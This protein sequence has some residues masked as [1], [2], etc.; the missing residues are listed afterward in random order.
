MIKSYQRAIRLGGGRR[1][2]VRD[3]AVVRHDLGREDNDALDRGV[4][5][6]ERLGREL[7]HTTGG[8]LSIR[9]A[10]VVASVRNGALGM[11]ETRDQRV[12]KCLRF[13]QAAFVKLYSLY[14]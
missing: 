9:E 5:H 2:V 12:G 8:R 1:L 7:A 13:V 10:E 4:A 3:L 6:A 14:I 11:A